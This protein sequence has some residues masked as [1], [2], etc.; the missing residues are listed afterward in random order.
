VENKAPR[1]SVTRKRQAIEQG[2]GNANSL[3]APF[4]LY[5]DG[6]ESV[7]FDVASHSS[8]EREQNVLGARNA[9]PRLYGRAPQ[10]VY[11]AG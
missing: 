4:M 5:D 2:F 10:Y 1:Q 6:T 3:R 9:L 11:S 8:M 7:L